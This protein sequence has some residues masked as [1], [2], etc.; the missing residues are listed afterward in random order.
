MA[1]AGL[2]NCICARFTWM[3]ISEGFPPVANADATR[4]ILGSMPGKAS[5]MANE[6]YAFNRNAFWKIMGNLYG[7]D[8]K[9]DYKNRLNI[10]KSEQIALWDV[11]AAGHR[12]GSL[13]SSISGQGLVINDFN[14]FFQQHPN[15]THVFF[16]GLKAASLFS[17]HVVKHLTTTPDLSTLPST[18]PAHAAM[19]F[20][21]K[22]DAWSV[23]K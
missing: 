1:F 6:Y 19:S 16:N 9:M 21:S 15:V 23:I 13:D 20:Q 2:T 3:N 4:L 11:V 18:S 17:K 10:L 8:P 7:A 12:P 5:L 22:L 14:Q